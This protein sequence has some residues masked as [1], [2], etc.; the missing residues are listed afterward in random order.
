MKDET[1]RWTYNRAVFDERLIGK[2]AGFVYN[3]TNLTNGMKYLG[4]KVFYFNRKVKGKRT[5]V[6]SD[7]RDY[8]G[9]NEELLKDVSAL[10]K[11]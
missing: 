6:E 3:I 2:M 11:R 8:F 5:K 4:K 7:W 1:N 10:R 9:S